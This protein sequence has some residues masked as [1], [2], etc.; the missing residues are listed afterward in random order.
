MRKVTRWYPD[1]CD[2]VIEYEWD[3]SESEEVRTH[4]LKRVVA[5]CHAHKAVDHNSLF[6]VV[7]EENRRKN[8]V[9]A[10]AQ[11]VREDLTPDKYRFRFDDKRNLIVNFLGVTPPEKAEI[12]RRCAE[13]YGNK[14]RLET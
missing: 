3:D 6:D 2:C 10:I 1:T 8:H 12:M 9:F 5:K 4:T 7:L 13:H 11:S 14:V